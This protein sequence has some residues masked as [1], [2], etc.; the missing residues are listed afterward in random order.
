MTGQITLVTGSTGFIGSRLLR[1]GDKA[2]VR[3]YTGKHNEI[4]GD[5]C[6]P[7]SLL[8]VCRGVTSIF[9][10]AGIAHLRT[11]S[12]ITLANNVNFHG[13]KNLLKVAGES[14]VRNFVYISSVKAM[15]SPGEQCV[16]EDWQGIPDDEYGL[17]KLKAEKAVL[18]AGQKF[19]MNVVNLRLAMVYGKNA[20]GNLNAMAKAINAGWFPPLPETGNRRSMVHV[21]DV[22]EAARLVLG[23]KSANQKTY[24]VAHPEAVSSKFLYDTLCEAL[25]GY[26]R[27]WSVPEGFFRFGGV[28]GDVVEKITKFNVQINSKLISKLLDSECYSSERLKNELGWEPKVNLQLG[29]KEMFHD[30]KIF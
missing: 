12:N 20:K 25:I 24:I 13:T 15:P 14:G 1:P 4:L 23:N 30:K 18:E 6:E 27:N 29:C 3:R 21:R 28:V 10:C 7:E 5:I 8:D 19:G 16:D 2:L 9:H 11:A 22:V 17:S 26:R